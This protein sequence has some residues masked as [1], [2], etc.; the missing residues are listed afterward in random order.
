MKKSIAVCLFLLIAVFGS[1]CST[2]ADVKTEAT[3]ISE[4]V[5]EDINVE[6]LESLKDTLACNEKQA[7]V[8]LNAVERAG[9]K[10][11]IGFESAEV[12]EGVGIRIATNTETYIVFMSS[13]YYV[14]AIK[15]ERTDDYIYKDIL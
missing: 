1:S 5:T 12:D 11:I 6:L 15:N 4:S 9:I 7:Q 14:Y 8:V 3:T 13:K 10:E 2:Q